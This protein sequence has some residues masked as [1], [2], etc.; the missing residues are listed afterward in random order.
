MKQ[1]IKGFHQDEES[2]WVANLSCGD[3]QHVRHDPPLICRQW[4][5][6]AEGRTTRLGVELDCK[7]CDEMGQSIADAVR[8][9]SLEVIVQALEA[10]GM[11]G[12]CKE[13]QLDLA[14]D[15][16]RAFDLKPVVETAIRGAISVSSTP[17]QPDDVDSTPIHNRT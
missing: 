6:T 9:K 13:S 3:K 17:F 11:S 8:V 7:W 5:V 15:A 14:T 12:L 10:A 4:V 2:H 16:L 1:M